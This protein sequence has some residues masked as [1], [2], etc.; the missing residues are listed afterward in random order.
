MKRIRIPLFGACIL[1]PLAG[2]VFADYEEFAEVRYQTASLWPETS[3]L[4]GVANEWEPQIENRVGQEVVIET[5]KLIS[6]GA[7][8]FC[9]DWTEPDGSAIDLRT[10]TCPDFSSAKTAMKR[11]LG[12]M[13]ST[14]PMDTGTNGLEH[15]GDICLTRISDFVRIL[16]VRN[17]VFVSLRTDAGLTVSTNLLFCLDSQIVQSLVDIPD[18]PLRSSPAPESFQAMRV[19]SSDSEEPS[20]SPPPAPKPAFQA[21]RIFSSEPESEPSSPAQDSE[22]PPDE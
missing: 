11:E 21:M 18:N 8:V 5:N 7:T 12:M 19:F 3:E 15:L 2:I 14:V 4:C 6:A 20:D 16:F 13:Q 22:S 10:Y 9:F 17:N 1:L